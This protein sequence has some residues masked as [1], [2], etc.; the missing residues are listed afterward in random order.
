MA[1]PVMR[2]DA[3]TLQQEEHHLS[4]PVVLREGPA[5]M[6]HDWPRAM[7]QPNFV[8][9]KFST[10][11]SVPQQWHVVSDIEVRA[12]P[13]TLSAIIVLPIHSGRE[14]R[15]WSIAREVGP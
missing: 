7:P 8:P 15:T 11:R 4:V 1:A 12:F 10:S 14:H 13:F 5:E 3:V 6:K 2:N 9:V